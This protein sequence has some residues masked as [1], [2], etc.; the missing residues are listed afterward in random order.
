MFNVLNFFSF[1][2]FWQ[3]FSSSVSSFDPLSS[4]SQPQTQDQ[5]QQ[6]SAQA[7]QFFTD[8]SDIFSDLLFG[9]QQHQHQPVQTNQ[10]HQSQQPIDYNFSQTNRFV[11]HSNSSSETLIGN[12]DNSSHFGSNDSIPNSL[13]LPYSLQQPI[14]AHHPV[15]SNQTKKLFFDRDSEDLNLLTLR[16]NSDPT[17]ALHSLQRA[18]L[19]QQHNIGLTDISQNA[20]V[21]VPVQVQVPLQS[22][23]NQASAAAA[24]AALLES[25]LP[26]FQE[27]YPIKYSNQLETFGLKMD[28]DCYMAQNHQATINYHHGHGHQHHVM[29]QEH[30]EYQQNPAAQFMAQNFYSYEQ[31]QQQQQQQMVSF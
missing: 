22:Q 3:N 17:I 28:E 7:Q 19:Q 11:E 1:S 15:D 26:S 13:A 4:S 29:H 8:S 9:Q 10:L 23:A 18:R 16:S 21:P 5:F 25:T 30:F 27:T 14:Q 12:T 2:F 6:Q 20:P 31:Q 24:A